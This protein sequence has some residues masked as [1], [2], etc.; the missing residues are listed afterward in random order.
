MILTHVFGEQLVVWALDRFV[1]YVRDNKS[2]TLQ[3]KNQIIQFVTIIKSSVPLLL[4][5]NR[6]SFYWN[7]SYYTLA[8]RLFNIRYVNNFYFINLF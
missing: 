5:L 6:V 4:S 2:I 1:Y 3:A 7:G 8:K